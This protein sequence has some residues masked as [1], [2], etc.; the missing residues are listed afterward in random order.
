MGFS[1]LR[2]SVWGGCLLPD[3][4]RK[5]RE[6]VSEI[7]KALHL[8]ISCIKVYAKTNKN[9]KKQKTENLPT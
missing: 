6:A 3:H 4:A 7:K 5:F 2:Y 9:P 1:L 8:K